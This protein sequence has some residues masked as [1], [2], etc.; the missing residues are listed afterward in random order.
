MKTSILRTVCLAIVIFLMNGFVTK[1]QEPFYDTTWNDDGR[2]VSRTKY[3]MKYSG[4]YERESVS[5]YTYDE[6]GNFLKKEVYLWNK[7][8]EWNDKAGRMYPDYSERNWT[9]QYCILHT[10]D[11][12]NNF[13]YSELLLWNKNKNTY[14]APAE[15]MILQL[16]GP[17]NINYLAFQKGGKYDEVTNNISYDKGLLA[18]VAK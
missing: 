17:N 3:V 2:M 14:D 13:T 6:E 8:Y 11:L 1:A 10:K 18:G 9:P 15:K 12:V 7:K 4:L 16:N 5:K